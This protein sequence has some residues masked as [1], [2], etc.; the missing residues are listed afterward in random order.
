MTASAVG[1]K[2][3]AMLAFWSERARAY[4]ADPRAN[5]ND[6][7]LRSLETGHASKL[8]RTHAARR[9]LDLGCGNGYTTRR[10]A[11]RHPDSTFLGIDIN[12]DMIAV[13]RAPAGDVNPPN[14]SFRRHDL[15]TVPLADSFDLAIAIRTFQNMPSLADQCAVADALLDHVRPGAGK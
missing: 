7:H 4:G 8:V 11:E 15:R 13:A 5:T 14:V 9:V 1:E 2:E 12:P 6:V 10:L 3:R